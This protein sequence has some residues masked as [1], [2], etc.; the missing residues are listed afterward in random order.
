MAVFNLSII[1]RVTYIKMAF[2][3][4]FL[5]KIQLNYWGFGVP[6]RINTKDMNKQKQSAFKETNKQTTIEAEFNLNLVA[7]TTSIKRTSKSIFPNKV[8]SG[9]LSFR[10]WW[11][12]KQKL[13]LDLNNI[14]KNN[15]YT[16]QTLRPSISI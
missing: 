14:P 13:R 12:N 6:L 11:S 16:R 2:K 10:D 5:N 4:I 9:Y 15:N 7:S 8:Q 3:S 1:D